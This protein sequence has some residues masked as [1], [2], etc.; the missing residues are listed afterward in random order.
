MVVKS[1]KIW[2]VKIP[3][4]KRKG[5]KILPSTARKDLFWRVSVD[6]ITEMNNEIWKNNEQ[7]GRSSS[8]S[9]IQPVCDT[10]NDE[11]DRGVMSALLAGKKAQKGPCVNE[12]TVLDD[13]DEIVLRFLRSTTKNGFG[14]VSTSKHL[15]PPDG[16]ASVVSSIGFGGVEEHKD[17]RE[18]KVHKNL[19]LNSI[20]VLSV[21]K[22]VCEFRKFDR[23]AGA[24]KCLIFNSDKEAVSF[25]Y[26]I[27]SLK[28]LHIDRF[29]KQLND[30]VKDIDL[31]STLLPQ[32]LKK[33]TLSI[34]R[35]D[36]ST[37][38]IKE[39]NHKSA[40]FPSN[41]LIIPKWGW[42]TTNVDNGGSFG[43]GSSK[44]NDDIFQIQPNS[45][46][47][48][49]DLVIGMMLNVAQEIARDKSLGFK[50]ATR[51]I[52]HYAGGCI[53]VPTVQVVGRV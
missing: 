43:S 12:H 29:N 4:E 31:K 10:A 22:N 28:K 42:N 32:Q 24:S 40:L 37:L 33:N 9:D 36:K 50:G 21:V 19:S 51:T 2:D 39:R 53:R 34:I 3:N 30:A 44:S 7:S 16:E 49:G 47:S 13:K 11:V 6:I 17:V 18:W 26:F 41:I 46:N 38:V 45:D 23:K 1:A 25:Y 27:K 35:N 15:P 14:D 20:D 52:I 48:S 5:I 8:S